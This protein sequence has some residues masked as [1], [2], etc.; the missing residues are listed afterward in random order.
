[1]GLRERRYAYRDFITPKQTRKKVS[2]ICC[3]PL[4]VSADICLCRDQIALFF[5]E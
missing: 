5:F 3:F 4:S 1:M 2:L